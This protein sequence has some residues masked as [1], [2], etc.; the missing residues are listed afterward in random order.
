MRQKTERG[1]SPLPALRW[2]KR[3]ASRTRRQLRTASAPCKIVHVE[4]SKGIPALPIQPGY[5][6]VYLV[7]WW[8][9]IPLGHVEL[10]AADFPLAPA[11]LA[12]LAVQA[13]TTA[14]G[15][16]FLAQGFNAA[17]D[18]NAAKLR[19]LPPPEW[20]EV[21]ALDSPLAKLAERAARHNNTALR[22][23]ISV[24]I[25]TRERP[26]QLAHCLA[27]LAALS[28]PPD[29]ILVVDNA[30]RTQATRD[31]VCQMP[32][33]RYVCEDRPGL[34]VARN[35]GIRHCRGDLIVFTDD[36][37]MVHRDWLV[38]MEEAFADANVMAVTGMVLPA[39]LETEAQ[40]IFE[41]EL[42]HFGWGYRAKRFDGEFFRATQGLGAPVW[43][44]GAGANMAFRRAI[45]DQVG[46]FDER[47]GA[48]ASGCSEDS[49]MWYRILAEGWGC[50]YDPLPVVFHLH[51]PELSSL[52]AQTYAYMRGH[53]TALFVQFARYRH[54]G[55]LLR[56]FVTLPTY[57][58]KLLLVGLLTGFG[59]RY[60]VYG[61]EMR[62]YLAGIRYYWQNR[63]KGTSRPGNQS[64]RQSSI[65]GSF[66][67]I[68]DKQ[69]ES[70]HHV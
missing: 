20:Q 36:D 23:T 37:V 49:E 62:G 31:L 29:E 30:P 14:V 28:R 11:T 44:I 47:L 68:R 57:Y 34:S 39:E 22:P 64:A 63:D 45:F 70:S 25:C 15:D 24:V 60:S 42:G 40:V 35:T 21:V 46:E 7:F 61:A 55:N 65:Q 19:P 1:A 52:Q 8:H 6:K 48:G 17:L 27:S 41:T 51:R 67:P 43:R 18:E 9:Q 59:P 50:R 58:A 12:N 66:G 4:L 16:H 3:N 38:R 53:V 54:W 13:I 56:L 69:A 10:W 33:V 26:A 32:G 2:Q 5:R